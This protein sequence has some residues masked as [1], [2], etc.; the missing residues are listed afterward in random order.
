[1]QIASDRLPWLGE[2][3][4]WVCANLFTSIR[5][6]DQSFPSP[7]SFSLS[8]QIQPKNSNSYENISASSNKAKQWLNDMQNHLA[9]AVPTRWWHILLS[10]KINI[11]NQTSD[12]HQSRKSL[13]M[14]YKLKA[15]HCYIWSEQLCQFTCFWNFWGLS[16]IVCIDWSLNTF[17]KLLIG[18]PSLWNYSKTVVDCEILTA[19]TWQ[20]FPSLLPSRENT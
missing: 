3:Y 14:D 6:S 12:F 15:S 19:S 13:L 16:L 4:P 10:I 18:I 8:H 20:T 11:L 17:I 7:F 9:M 5:M 1:M 2:T